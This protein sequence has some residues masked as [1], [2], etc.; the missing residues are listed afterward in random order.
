MGRRGVKK[1]K[2]D[3]AKVD[4]MCKIQCT[5][6]EICSIL[7]ISEDTLSRRCEEDHNMRFAEYS[8]IKR[9]GGKASLRRTQWQ[10]A[11]KNPAMAMFLGKNLLG[12]SDRQAIDHTT[13]GEKLSINIVKNYFTIKRQRI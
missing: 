7:D 5:A 10:H 6:S 12:Q 3:W 1:I 4:N 9:E 2:V 8:T 13:Q 11:E